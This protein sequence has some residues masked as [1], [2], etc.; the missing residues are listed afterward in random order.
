VAEARGEARL[1]EEHAEE[2]GIFGE[3]RADLLDDDQ[4]VEAR[5]PRDRQE[6]LGHAAV[7][8]LRDEPVLADWTFSSFRRIRGHR[9]PT[10][11]GCASFSAPEA[12]LAV[13]SSL[14]I[15]PAASCPSSRSPL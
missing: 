6:D 5:G 7:A 8:E 11:A 10:G 13:K 12:Q 3:L 1:V 15:D 9:A 4:L 2:L 14:R